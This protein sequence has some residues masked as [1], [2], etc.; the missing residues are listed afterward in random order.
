MY[1][2]PSVLEL[3]KRRS[4]FLPLPGLAVLATYLST[5]SHSVYPGYPATLAAQAAG[6]IPPSLAAHPLFSWVARGVVSLPGVT[7]PLCLHVFSALCG[8]LCAMALYQL[9]SRTILF[10]ACE[11]EGGGGQTDL[12]QGEDGD[13]S[14]PVP[15]M[16]PEVAAHNRRLWRIA[17][18]GGVV[19]ALIFAFTAPVWSASTQLDNGVFT[20]L[21]T[22]GSLGFIPP[23]GA[24]A[25]SLRL[26]LSV[27]LFVLGSFESAVLLLLL[28]WY[29]FLLFR[30]VMAAPSRGS[31]GCGIVLAGIAAAACAVYAFW[32]NTPDPA[33]YATL[34]AAG[35]AFARPLAAH[36]YYETLAFF[37]RQGW[38]LVALQ[39]GFPS[40]ML[41]LGQQTLFKEKGVSTLIALPLLAF[42]TVP[43][44]LNLSVSP[45]AV[46]P[47]PVCLPVF[48]YA[49]LAAAIAMV[50]SAC[51][52]MAGQ[53]TNQE[54]DDD[55]VDEIEFNRQFVPQ[56]IVR[57]FS[58]VLLVGLCVLMVAVPWRSS[59]CV[60]RHQA[61]FADR[62]ARKML[63]EMKER[64]YLITNGL[65]DNHLLIQAALMKKP[66]TVIP[67]RAR[68]LPEEIQNTRR[69]IDTSPIFE[70]YNRQRFQNALT[71]GTVPF[72][73]E[74]FSADTNMGHRAMIF[75][76]PEIWNACGYRPVPEG[77]AFGGIREDEALDL[78]RLEE[79]NR[80]FSEELA[81]LLARQDKERG[82]IAFL[83]EMLR[84]KAGFA[85]NE[86]GVLLEEKDRVQEAYAAYARAGKIDPANVSAS[87]N[88]YLLATTR[89]LF[90]ETHD[91]LKN[92][93]TAALA[94]YGNREYA[95]TAISQ[96]YGSIRHPAF[97]QQQTVAWS[98]R[99]G[100]AVASD[101]IRK[102]LSLSKQTGV[103]ALVENASVYLRM[104]DVAKAEAG[105]LAALKEDAANADALSGLCTLLVGQKRV[106]EA[107]KWLKTAQ[108]AGINKEKIFYPLIMVAILKGEKEL[109]A[110]LLAEATKKD[111]A[112]LRYWTLQADLL[113]S[114]GDT[115]LVEQTVLPQMQ[116]VLKNKDHF[117]VHAIRGSLLRK[118]GTRYYKEA[119]LSYLEALALNAALP[120]I[121]RALLELDMT[122][123]NP[124]FT[125]TDVRNQLRIDPE[126][127]LANYLMGSM[128]LARGKLKESEDFL[129]R[130]IEKK[131]TCVACN[132]LAE[133]FRL[134]KRL[135]EA[136]VFARRALE[137]EPGLVQAQDTLACVLLALGRFE[138]AAQIAGQ[139]VDAQPD[140]PMYRVTL[141]R[142]QVK[143]GNRDGAL[144]QLKKLS[145]SRIA[146]PDELQQEIKAMR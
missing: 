49:V 139:A 4:L 83:R 9:V 121:W 117:L 1:I 110:G 20:L 60:G 108:A 45:F 50:F 97:Y 90:P 10:S 111:S 136:E 142:A 138:E 66:L 102:A 107:E 70:G 55:A 122:I 16:P 17:V 109:A 91:G 54:T 5:V 143:L 11:D 47:P 137:L 129:R 112:D 125:E 24:R 105:Y 15:A 3:A 52:K 74:W 30:A 26:T 64:S 51:L 101:K 126:N 29:L 94:K 38:L 92:K 14:V 22:L 73:R 53:K 36:H 145:E 25:Y 2:H 86:L 7:L 79:R 67:L 68:E 85:A 23:G 123:K 118:K 57:G 37:P 87:V 99:G 65:L 89:G 72:V 63:D 81:P 140:F 35:Q 144:Q 130:S 31:A 141:L 84:M 80:V 98:A 44:L 33:A 119:R 120:D 124:A 134:Q 127:A 104:G 146:L 133:N 132:D 21:L 75:A 114:Q 78:D 39:F 96:K 116:K 128:L 106:P 8:T 46:L 95:L 131:P 40:V 82:K 32:Q 48:G 71:L 113:L 34:L 61:A 103:S 88:G 41:L 100:Q 19:A 42:F 93:V 56:R 76:T 27:F 43:G 59:R 18:A 135:P 115:Q 77:L 6:V 28:P 69:F 58:E 12:A 13:D 62:I